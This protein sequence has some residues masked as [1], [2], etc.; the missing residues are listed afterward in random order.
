MAKIYLKRD[1]DFIV[2][3]DEE[4]NIFENQH[5]TETRVIGDEGKWPRVEMTF[6]LPE[7][8]KHMASK[9]FKIKDL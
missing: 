3:C 7:G 6:L 5:V 1:K 4:G 2:L 9:F 8:E